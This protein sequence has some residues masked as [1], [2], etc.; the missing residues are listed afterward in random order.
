MVIGA[1]PFLS[2]DDWVAT[3][4]FLDDLYGLNDAI[5]LNSPDR[6]RQWCSKHGESGN[7]TSRKDVN[8]YYRDFTALSSDLTPTKM[9]A[10]DVHLC[11]YR[12]IPASLR[13][14]I[15]K[16][17]PAANLKTSSPP[18]TST[19]LTLLRA[20]FDE[21]DL[22]AKTTNVGVDL[23]SD[24]DSS[25]SDSEEDIDRVVLTKKKK[26]PSKKVTFEKT[27]PAAPIVEPVDLSPV[28]RLT[29]QMEDLRLAHAEFL[30]SVNIAPNPNL[31]NQQIMREARCF[32]CDKTTHRLGLK[33]CPEVEVCIK[34]GL[35]AY[36]PLGRLAHPDGSELPRAFGSDGGVAKVLREQH[37]ASSHLKGKA[38]EASRDLPP[39]MANY[40]GLLFD[41]QEV[42][43][44]EVFNA[45]TSSVV[46]E[47]CA[48]PSSTLAVTH[49]QKDK[50][51]CFDPIKCPEKQQAKAKSTPKTREPPVPT[52]SNL[53]PANAPVQST[54]QAFNLRPPAV[55]STPQAFNLQP[56]PVNTEDAFKNRWTASSKP[57]GINT[58]DVEMKDA[59]TK[60]KSAP[61]YHFTSDIQEM[62]DLEK[63]VQE[64]VNKTLV[65]LELGELL[66]ISAFLQK[67]VS[68][69]TKTHREYV[70]KP[71]V[72]NIVEVLEETDWAEEEISSLELAGGYDS[73]DEDY[74]RSLPEAESFT[75]SG[76]IESCIGLEFDESAES[77]E[78]ILIRYASAVKIHLTPQPLFAMVTGCFR[79]KFAGLDVVFMVDTGSELNLMS[80][81]FYDGT[82]LAIDLN[83]TRWSLKGINRWPVPLGG[84]VRDAEIKI[85]GRRFD[86]HVFV[87][88]EGTGKQ[89]IILGQP[90]LQWYSASIQ[91]TRKG[92]MSM[93]IW[94]DGDGD[95]LEGCSCSPSILI[96]LCTPNAPRNTS[97]LNL[98][99][100]TRV[101]EV[102]DVDAGK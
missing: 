44:S 10:N 89:E 95:T 38:Q 84:C 18:S 85:S 61:S 27:V 93:R 9:L 74:Y 19:L 55:Q 1:S 52:L 102:E 80:Q 66:V 36:T 12:G 73:D 35:V 5:L 30:R 67:S 8:K 78:E 41:G 39:H 33:F 54:P 53:R 51:T 13:V 11:F 63:I 57:K 22:D 91:Y 101:E 28:D 97:S 21:E 31:T 29:K 75:N 25:S 56:P 2:G 59:N 34:E 86:H 37:A 64:K 100:G 4:V 46:P 60:A 17:I 24:S 83:R 40:A 68:N 90:W 79:G 48:S 70:S 69:M 50:E 42:L 3:R 58:K 77:K 94:Q 72:A 62:Y 92:S 49:S 99:H 47:W 7:I 98:D 26:K 16:R 23:D 6:L 43:S 71:V 45:S 82:R 15:K 32:F 76:F 65:H 88:R 96:P 14:R 20:E 87:S 81:E